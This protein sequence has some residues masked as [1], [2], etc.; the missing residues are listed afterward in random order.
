[1]KDKPKN[2]KDV[3]TFS[4]K[5]IESGKRMAILSYILPFIPYFVEKENKYVKYHAR[6][7]MDL[8]VVGIGFSIISTILR[9]VIKVQKN[10]GAW[11]G[12]PIPCKVTPWWVSYP[13]GLI[14]LGLFALAIMG[15]VNAI[16]GKA[17]PLPLFENFK[18]F[19]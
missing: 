12:I 3:K 2:T 5:E 10:C 19:K 13:L 1:M 15:L 7:G 9:N 16:N 17:K 4:K 14:S 6:Q 8:L 18:I 11:F